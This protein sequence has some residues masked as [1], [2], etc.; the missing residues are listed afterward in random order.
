MVILDGESFQLD[1]KFIGQGVLCAMTCNC[2]IATGILA[3]GRIQTKF[4]KEKGNTNW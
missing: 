1:C 3:Q 4:R 2:K